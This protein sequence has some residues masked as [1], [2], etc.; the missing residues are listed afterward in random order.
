MFLP[1]GPGPGRR[2]PKP[3][4]AIRA[5]AR[6]PRLLLERLEDR[7]CPSLTLTPAGLSRGLSLTT[8]AYNIP[9][10]P[11]GIGPLGIAFPSSG[12]VLVS[13]HDGE[14]R[15]FP[16]DA[17]RQDAAQVP[18]TQYYGLDNAL[19]MTNAN[20]IIYMAGR[21]SQTVMQLND[22][23]TFNRVAASGLHFLGLATDPA[24]G[25]L[26]ASGYEDSELVDVDP[27]TG[28][29]TPID[30]GR[31][32]DG[33]TVSAD[34]NTLYAAQSDAGRIIGFDLHTGAQVFD[35]GVID[36]RPD[37]VIEGTGALSDYIYVN[38]NAG[39][40][41]E[42]NKTD[43]TQS[44]VASGGSRGDFA[45]VDPNGSALLTQT[46]SIVRLWF[47]HGPATHFALTA[48][49]NPVFPFQLFPVTVQALDAS[50]HADPTYQG[51]VHFTSTDPLAALPDDY[52][53]TSGDAGAH[54]FSYVAMFTAGVQTITATDTGDATITG[55]ATVT[56]LPGASP[57]FALSPG[58]DRTGSGPRPLSMPGDLKLT[59]PDQPSRTDR[60]SGGQGAD[61]SLAG[62]LAPGHR[63]AGDFWTPDWGGP[64]G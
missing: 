25:H 16:S 53:F 58:I 22:D 31:M 21:A 45:H 48:P 46:D 39:T 60:L 33:L 54:T 1:F 64:L 10:D 14:V 36:G 29:L 12:G 5:R 24:T 18:V 61:A 42:V 3:A 56:V 55:S 43:L 59:S 13:D 52:T 63:K 26:L 11:A 8:F 9:S 15:R 62:L 6:T 30:T 49:T 47:T 17:D 50:N 57:G 38:T 41:V 40:V 20:G 27:A 35:S 28:A 4:K 51:T 19:D 44:V 2:Q 23:G 37:G 32:F 7:D 34:G